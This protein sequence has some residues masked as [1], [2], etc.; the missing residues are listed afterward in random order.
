MIS[1]SSSNQASSFAAS[2]G[3][4]M[5][6]TFMASGDVSLSATWPL[7][8][9]AFTYGD[10]TS[11]HI[12]VLGGAR[13]QDPLTGLDGLRVPGATPGDDVIYAGPGGSTIEGGGGADTLH[14]GPGPDLFI[15][16]L[17]DGND[18]IHGFDPQVD[19]LVILGASSL[20]MGSD[21][22]GATVHLPDGAI[23]TLLLSGSGMDH[24]A[25]QPAAL[26]AHHD[27]LFF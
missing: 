19:R 16:K 20:T 13:G 6:E 22:A 8:S 21:P 10:G 11:S 14:S 7:Q 24:A 9:Y 3:G 12:S 23:I 27:C 26:L 18:T 5:P 1:V 17:G 4:D 2:P 15:Y 25:I